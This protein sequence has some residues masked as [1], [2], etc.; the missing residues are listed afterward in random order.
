MS[1]I[2]LEEPDIARIRRIRRQ[3]DVVRRYRQVNKSARV[4]RNCARALRL[5]GMFSAA[6][7][8]CSVVWEA[9]HHGL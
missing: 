9:I 5:I 8:V 2:Y 1:I 7:A 3:A 4:K 6:L